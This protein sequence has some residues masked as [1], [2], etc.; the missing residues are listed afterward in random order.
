M[1]R[2]K[3]RFHK[4][5]LYINSF[6]YTLNAYCQI[7]EVPQDLWS[8]LPSILSGSLL[9]SRDSPQIQVDYQP[10]PFSISP[11][12]TQVGMLGHQSN[13]L[14]FVDQDELQGK[15]NLGGR[16]KGMAKS[17][18]PLILKQSSQDH[19]LVRVSPEWTPHW[20]RETGLSPDQCIRGTRWYWAAIPFKLESVPCLPRVRWLFF[21]RSS[22]QFIWLQPSRI[23][24]YPESLQVIWGPRWGGFFH[25]PLTWILVLEK[26]LCLCCKDS[27]PTGFPGNTHISP[28]NFFQPGVASHQEQGC[29]TWPIWVLYPDLYTWSINRAWPRL[30][31]ITLMGQRF[32]MKLITM[33]CCYGCC[34]MSSRRLSWLLSWPLVILLGEI[35]QLGLFHQ[36]RQYVLLSLLP[37]Q[38]SS[39]WLFPLHWIYTRCH[40]HWSLMTV[41][42][43]FGLCSFREFLGCFKGFFFHKRSFFY[44]QRIGQV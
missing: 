24:P 16:V 3:E 31:Q 33:T 20:I 5:L 42:V 39:S 27:G 19:G 13:N 18:A 38:M 28:S 2:N 6:S 15:D 23:Y 34:W 36:Q 22:S 25:R 9:P 4:Y 32:F 7:V 29:A 26:L 30:W 44:S 43:Y 14:D 21:L 17:S 37:W 35:F 8:T 1:L 41:V 10:S 12:A 40:G 11:I